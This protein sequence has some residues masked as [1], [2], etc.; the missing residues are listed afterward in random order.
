VGDR[1]FKT[2]AATPLHRSVPELDTP[3]GA[4]GIKVAFFTGCVIDKVF[5]QVGEAAL[6]VLAQKGVGVFL[7]AD[8]ACCGIPALSSGDRK[9]FDKL[10]A[11]NMK[12]F[13]AFDF[14]YLL[15]ACATCTSTIKELWPRMFTGDA[16][17]MAGI[18]ELADKTMDI[19]QLLVDVI[20]VKVVRTAG[21]SNVTYHDPCHLKNGL[22]ITAQPR[23]LIKAAG[24]TYREMREAG[25]CCG[26]GGSFNIAHYDLSKKIGAR[27]VENIIESGADTLATSCPACMLHITDMLSRKKA[28][29]NVKHVIELYADALKNRRKTE[30]L[31][32]F[33]ERRRPGGS[34]GP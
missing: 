11:M 29:I 26:C 33:A 3:A 2:L 30:S 8:Q 21:G 19:S 31:E 17:L 12:H 28:G 5:P 14:D 34:L 18:R 25:S 16:A 13:A 6:A 9:T 23:T 24:C 7:P 15:S 32:L 1:H 10:V 22:G 20:G 4:S 27:K